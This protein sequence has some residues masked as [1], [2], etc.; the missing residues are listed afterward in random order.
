MQRDRASAD[1]EGSMAFFN[2]TS[3]RMKG[4]RFGAVPIRLRGGIFPVVCRGV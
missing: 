4:D 3:R 2:A 1:D